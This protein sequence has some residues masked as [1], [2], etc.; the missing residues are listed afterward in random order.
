M[1]AYRPVEAHPAGLD[2]LGGERRDVL[3]RFHARRQGYLEYLVTLERGP[4]NGGDALRVLDRG[5][6]DELG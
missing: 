1:I 4:Q 3:L 2:N 6:A 5:F